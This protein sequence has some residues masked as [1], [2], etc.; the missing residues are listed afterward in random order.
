MGI[1]IQSSDLE[2]QPSTTDLARA[3]SA[4]QLPPEYLHAGRGGA[5]N[6]YQ[7]AELTAQGLEQVVSPD[8]TAPISPTSTSPAFTSGIGIS[9]R[10]LGGAK[11]T[12]RGGRGGAGNY[13]DF[14]EEERLRKERAEMER[15][16]TEER[17]TRDVEAGLARPPKAYGG[18]AGAWELGDMK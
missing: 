4:S 11:P 18:K 7:P 1:R 16:E 14:A 15:R 12:Y 2:A 6:W 8:A 9:K 13:T 10:V 17:I 3:L 5:G